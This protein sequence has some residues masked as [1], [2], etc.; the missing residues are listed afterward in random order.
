MPKQDECECEYE[1]VIVRRSI[2]A[3]LGKLHALCTSSLSIISAHRGVGE[4]ALGPHTI[5]INMWHTSFGAHSSLNVPSLFSFKIQEHVRSC[6]I[7]CLIDASRSSNCYSI[8]MVD[9]FCKASESQFCN[10]YSNIEYI[11]PRSVSIMY[12]PREVQ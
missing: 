7:D 2:I 9:T 8:A 5:A 11:K 3:Y 10:R 12:A 1:A 6:I 4:T